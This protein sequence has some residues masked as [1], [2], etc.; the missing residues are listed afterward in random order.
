MTIRYRVIQYDGE[1]ADVENLIKRSIAGRFKPGNV[2]ISAWEAQPGD[3]VG[4]RAGL[5]RWHPPNQHAGD[6]ADSI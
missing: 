5:P 4:P 3:I 6:T 2:I 1:T